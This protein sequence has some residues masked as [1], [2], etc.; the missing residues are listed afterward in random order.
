M[1]TH[2]EA[3]WEGQVT[4]VS[5]PLLTPAQLISS[6]NLKFPFLNTMISLFSFLLNCF[7]HLAVR[8]SSAPKLLLL[9][10]LPAGAPAG[11]SWAGEGASGPRGPDSR[12]A[13][14]SWAGGGPRLPASLQPPLRIW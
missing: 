10:G 4:F 3:E 13:G 7:L 9:G 5:N 1:D 11:P 12:P 8:S 6:L 14:C 2:P